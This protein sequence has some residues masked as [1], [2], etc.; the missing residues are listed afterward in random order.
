MVA[1]YVSKNLKESGRW[2]LERNRLEMLE[3]PA[4]NLSFGN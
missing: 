3:K 4:S 1:T 2:L